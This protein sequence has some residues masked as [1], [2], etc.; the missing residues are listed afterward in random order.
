MGTITIVAMRA[1][2]GYRGV[3]PIASSFRSL[4][5]ASNVICCSS[6]V[7]STNSASSGQ[8]AFHAYFA[9][10]FEGGEMLFF[11]SSLDFL[12]VNLNN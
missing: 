12:V 9:Y 6:G 8:R 7:Y 4:L 3:L 5:C 10:H 2:V 11:H 1:A